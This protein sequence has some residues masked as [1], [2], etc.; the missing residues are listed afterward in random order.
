MSS[1]VA[2]PARSQT[3]LGNAVPARPRL[4]VFVRQAELAE[5]CVPRES[6]GT[7]GQRAAR[8]L[9]T[10]TAALRPLPAPPLA[11]YPDRAPFSPTRLP[12]SAWPHPTT[13]YLVAE[14]DD[15]FG[16]VYP[17]QRGVTYGVGRSPKNRVVLADDLCQPRPR[18]GRLRRGRLVRPRPRQPQRHPRQRQGHPRRPALASGDRVQ[19]GRTRFRF[20]DD[21]A[22]LPGIPETRPQALEDAIRITRRT[23]KTKFLPPAGDETDQDRHRQRAG[24]GPGRRRPVPPGPRHGVRQDTSRTWPRRS[25][26]ACS[27]ASP[28]STGRSWPSRPRPRAGPA[29]PPQPGRAGAHLPQGVATRRASEV[30]DTREAILA[31]NVLQTDPQYATRDSLRELKAGEPD[32]RPGPGRRPGARAD[33]PVHASPAAVHRR[34]PGIRPGRRPADGRR[35]GPAPPP[36]RADQ[37]QPGAQASSWP[38]RASWSGRAPPSSRSSR[39]SQRVAGHDGHGADP[40][41]ERVR[42][43][44]GRPGHPLLEPAARR[45]VRLASTARP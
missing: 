20:V 45:A 8:S 41:R 31:D 25:S 23:S 36:G 3:P 6:L 10:R 27:T 39:R 33:P 38:W 5:P 37:H 16:D 24:P 26:P 11:G 1:F 18:R 43:G 42:Q 29:R 4:A 28:P 44:T 2:I 32:L 13:A 17:L 12:G 21:L 30:L 40:R 22:E 35:L 7:S 34:R 15:G 14:R 9:G 19:F